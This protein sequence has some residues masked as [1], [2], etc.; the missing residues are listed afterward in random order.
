[1]L[2]REALPCRCICRQRGPRRPDAQQSAK[3][4]EHSVR[5]YQEAIRPF[6]AFLC[7]IFQVFQGAEDLD[8]ASVQW[9]QSAP[10]SKANFEH[11]AAAKNHALAALWIC[12]LFGYIGYQAA[13]AVQRSPRD[14]RR[15]ARLHLR[16]H[17]LTRL[18]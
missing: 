15:R 17:Y 3:I 14:R 12:T 18:D 8:D 4:I 16:Q 10:V 9:K 7:E 13:A 1:M 11:A 5:R 2:S 6:A